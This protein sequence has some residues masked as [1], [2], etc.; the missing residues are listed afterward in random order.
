[1]EAKADAI[2]RLIKGE[3]PAAVLTLASRDAAEGFPDIAGFKTFRVPL[4][5]RARL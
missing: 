5:L 3:V 4:S 2:D 1:L